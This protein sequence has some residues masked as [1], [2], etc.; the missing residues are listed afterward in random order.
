MLLAYCLIRTHGPTNMKTISPPAAIA[1]V[2]LMLVCAA[3]SVTLSQG[4]TKSDEPTLPAKRQ[5]PPAQGF[6]RFATLQTPAFGVRFE[7]SDQLL[8]KS[9]DADLALA[10]VLKV[11]TRSH[12]MPFTG[13]G[14]GKAYLPA[15]LTSLELFVTS[16]GSSAQQNLRLNPFVTEWEYSASFDG[17]QNVNGLNVMIREQKRGSGERPVSP[18]RIYSVRVSGSNDLLRINSFSLMQ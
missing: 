16:N 10:Y 8:N 5:L 1:L 11:L 2:T 12:S 17:F 18:S 13:S 9:A 4:A 6:T 15:D 14:G 7:L 3:P